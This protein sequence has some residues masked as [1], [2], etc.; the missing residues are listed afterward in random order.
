MVEANNIFY[1]DRP[2]LREL[3]RVKMCKWALFLLWLLLAG[4]YFLIGRITPYDGP[5]PP[6]AKCG[7]FVRCPELFEY[8]RASNECRLSSHFLEQIEEV[9]RKRVEELQLEYGQREC[10]QQDGAPSFNIDHLFDQ[11][12]ADKLYIYREN[13]DKFFK[14][15]ANQERYGFK[16]AGYSGLVLPTERRYTLRCR[17]F[18]AITDLFQL[19]IILGCLVG[20]GVLAWLGWIFTRSRRSSRIYRYLKECVMEAEDKTLNIS[21]AR[22]DL[23]NRFGAITNEEWDRIDGVRASDKKIAYFED[24]FLYW[25]AS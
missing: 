13:A 8:H 15:K 21:L 23:E 7:V 18:L 4:S 17:L 1:E 16:L 9:S 20:V 22:P 19:S 24:D 25:K 2:E 6:R 10:L 14:S 5:C 11:I 12:D 3:E